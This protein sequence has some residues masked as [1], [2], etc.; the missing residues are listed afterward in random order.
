MSEQKVCGTDPIDTAKTIKELEAL[1]DAMSKNQCY[2]CSHDFIDVVNEFGTNIIPD[3][4]ELIKKLQEENELLQRNQSHPEQ[5][6][7]IVEEQGFYS[8]GGRTRAYEIHTLTHIC[9]T[10]E[11]AEKRLQ[12]WIAKNHPYPEDVSETQASCFYDEVPWK[13]VDEKVFNDH[14]TAEKDVTDND[15]YGSSET[16]MFYEFVLEE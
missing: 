13:V 2:T 11:L 1:D 4:V 8:E 15:G 10:K 7:W 6:V 9:A 12:E 14:K 5:K 16:C 3:A